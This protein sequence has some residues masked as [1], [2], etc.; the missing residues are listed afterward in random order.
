MPEPSD[1]PMLNLQIKHDPKT[2]DTV[3]ARARADVSTADIIRF[4]FV[5]LTTPTLS[6]TE[7]LAQGLIVPESEGENDG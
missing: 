5:A 1:V 7:H 3:L 2:V 6:L 4:A